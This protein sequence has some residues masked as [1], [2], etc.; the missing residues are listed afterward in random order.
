MM[1]KSISTFFYFVFLSLAY[2]KCLKILNPINKFQEFNQIDFKNEKDKLNDSEIK[3]NIEYYVN[4]ET[5]FVGNKGTLYYI[6]EYNDN[7]KNIF[8]SSDIEEKTTF[9][10]Y[11]TEKSTNTNYTI[12]CRLWKPTHG[13]LRLFCKLKDF[14]EK[15]YY[16]IEIY[17]YN[18]TYGNYNIFVKFNL[19]ETSFYQVDHFPFLY[20]F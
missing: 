17:S 19:G 5:Q 15:N 8:N 14:F 20:S 18:F 7:E 12:T 3:I 13:N 9:Q 4:R 1:K 10:T 16:G 2:S 6:T 11:F